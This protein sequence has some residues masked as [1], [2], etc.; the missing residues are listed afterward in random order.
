M[1]DGAPLPRTLSIYQERALVVT[2]IDA[3]GV[4]TPLEFNDR[5]NTCHE[6]LA[7]AET[8]KGGR[9]L[10]FCAASLRR[11]C[12]QDSVDPAPGQCH[13]PKLP[14]DCPLRSRGNVEAV[15]QSS[16]GLLIPAGISVTH[17][18]RL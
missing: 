16:Y 3:R 13:R 10:A 12:E 15:L 6:T 7:T 2:R 8:M 4:N 9:D 14:K 5:G 1:H 17:F 11:P 18:P